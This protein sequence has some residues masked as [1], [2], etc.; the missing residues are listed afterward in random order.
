MYLRSIVVLLA[1]FAASACSEPLEFADW[2]IPVPDGTPILEYAW[3]P[4]EERT[5]VVETERDLVLAEAFGRPLYQPRKVR[6]DENGQIFVLDGGNHRVVVFDAHGAPLLEMGKEGQGPGEFQSVRAFGLLGDSVVVYD[7]RNVRWSVYR[8]D[9]TH[10]EDRTLDDRI[11]PGE[12]RDVGGRLLIVNADPAFILPDSEELP[13]M[14]W[15]AGFYAIEDLRFEAVVEFEYTF[16]LHW[17]KDRS[18][19]SVP[20]SAPFPRGALA[21]AVVY[22]TD[23]VEYQVR[24]FDVDGNVGWA[25][26]TDYV[27][28]SVSEDAKRAVVDYLQEFIPGLAYQHF[29]WPERYA[30]I[31]NLEVDGHGN[32]W[33]FSHADRGPDAVRGADGPVPVDVYS[34]EGERLFSGMIAIAAWDSALGDHVYRIETDP[35]TEEQVVARYRLVEPFE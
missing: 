2:T 20:L 9:G 7:S 5:D 18:A 25:L 11:Y 22:V 35:D 14:F 12:M 17:E 28:P 30:A 8:N 10:V 32:L 26:R 31:E 3:V 33:V 15:R 24:A 29:T 1:L 6:A 23:G 4:L 19:G 21:D 34:P 13:P 27:V 16:D